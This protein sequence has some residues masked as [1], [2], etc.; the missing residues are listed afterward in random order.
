V[1]MT[2]NGP[3][4]PSPAEGVSTT[5]MTD[6]LRRL[7]R[8]EV[9]DIVASGLCM[10]CGA[11]E[12]VAGSQALTMHWNAR[13]AY[14]PRI[15][16]P[17]DAPT[18]ARIRAICPGLRM[19]LRDGAPRAP[20]AGASAGAGD[21]LFL[22]HV[23][24]LVE[25][26]AADPEARFTGSSGGVLSA[27]AIH[28]LETGE[29]A[30]VL[31][32]APSATQPVRSQ[33]QISRTRAD[34]LR[35][36]GSRYGPAA[37]LA[38]LGE[39]LRAGEPFAVIGKPCDIAAVRNL[40]RRLPRVERQ[41]VALL[42]VMCGGQAELP[43]ILEVLRDHGVA[44]EEVTGFRCR[45]NGC[46]GPTAIQTA[47][48]RDIRLT[49]EEVW[50][51][52]IHEWGLPF[53]CKICP[54]SQ[55]EQADLLAFDSVAPEHAQGDSEGFNSVLV[56]TARGRELLDA[57]EQAGTVAVARELELSDVHKWQTHIIRRREGALPRLI[58]AALRN[59]VVPRVSGYRLLRASAQ[60]GIR[61]FVRNA[62]GAWRRAGRARE[63]PS[64]PTN[65][66]HIAQ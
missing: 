4:T 37:P 54:D 38:L 42:T 29:V 66:T 53:R 35:A 48:G 55:G 50:G 11:C 32:V 46:P 21:D 15:R 28:L 22:G 56:R 8:P 16:G 52:A 45:G 40:S 41:V 62:A 12:A 26:H 13:D 3:A 60:G 1:A 19:E 44:E 34:V 2:R 23:E 39:L 61:S 63:I 51:D 27:L 18:Q 7:V 17:L 10:G 24:R 64:A 47:D 33:A 5:R 30:A 25:A 9:E 58:G 6:V 59:G 57:A 31:H 20:S 36:A 65:T 43:F 49:Y 14:R